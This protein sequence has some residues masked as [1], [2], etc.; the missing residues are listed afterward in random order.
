[1]NQRVLIGGIGNVLL[2]DDAVGPYV[3]RL[4]ESQYNFGDDVEIADLGTPALD[5]T[6]RIA[7]LHTVILVD[8]ITSDEH[9]PGTILL[10][11]KA[12]ILRAQPAQRLDPHSP[13]L[14]ECLMTAEMLG[15]SP[16][17]LTLIG[18]VGRHFNPGHRLSPAVARGAGKSVIA[19]LS[20]LDSL[21]IRYERRQPVSAPEI[22]WSD[23]STVLRG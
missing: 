22:W 12:D 11:H 9:P 19:V 13:A 3:I 4:L 18:V 1:M 14:S 15:A 10:Y 20:E 7:G 6:H 16:D 17:H 8:C 21:G 2:G 23:N 5:L